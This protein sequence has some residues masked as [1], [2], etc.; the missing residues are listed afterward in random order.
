MSKL[1]LPKATTSAREAATPVEGEIFYDQNN[2]KLYY[3]DGATAGGV[4]LYPASLGAGYV[5]G[6]DHDT[7]VPTAASACKKVV[8]VGDTILEVEGN[9]SSMPAHNF[10]R[11]VMSDLANRVVNYYLS[12]S[13]STK[14][15]NGNPAV[16]TGADGDV[17]VEIP[18]MHWR[19]DTYTDIDSHVHNRYLVS[20]RPFIGSSVHPYFYVSPGGATARAQYVGA[21]KAVHCDADGNAKPWIDAQT[22]SV[23]AAGDKLR[24]ILGWKPRPALRH[25]DFISG[26]SAAGGSVANFLFYR[27]LALMMAVEGGTFDS[28][29][30]FSYGFAGLEDWKVECAR[31]PGRT[32]AFGNG[33]GEVV[34][35]DAGLDADLLT[36]GDEGVSLWPSSPESK[37]VQFSYRGIEDPYG[38]TGQ[39][40]TGM[41]TRRSSTNPNLSGYWMTQDTSRY[42][43]L[44]TD[45][46]GGSSG[47][48]FPTSGY[49]GPS[50]AWV[51]HAWG[52][53]IGYGKTFTRDTLLPLLNDGAAT[54]G[55]ADSYYPS[56]EADSNSPLVIGGTSSSISRAGINFVYLAAPLEIAT[57]FSTCSRI[58]A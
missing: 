4:Q 44:S 7:A 22:P 46:G 54:L 25:S 56:I 32:V 38:S 14:K 40:A 57:S 36:L 17:M 3:G 43:L 12:A 16:L 9:F 20:D 48:V 26:A 34:A 53:T 47:S 10:K 50:L 39:L 30:A 37:V 28:Q 55:L 27:Y 11:C 58:S 31:L 1:I 24:S 13:D 18:V 23:Y 6:I 21:F 15:E 41:Q 51:S 8:A 29:A 2:K 49:S 52:D 45:R 35:D 33:T 19:I 42:S 5:Y